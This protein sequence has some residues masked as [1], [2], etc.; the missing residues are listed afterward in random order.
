MAL[1]LADAAVFGFADAAGF[2]VCPPGDATGD[3]PVLGDPA[4]L[5]FC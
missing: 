2:G 3:L 5:G 4:P 1:G